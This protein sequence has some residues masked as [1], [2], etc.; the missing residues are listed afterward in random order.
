[1]SV[2][3]NSAGALLVRAGKNRT[4]ETLGRFFDDG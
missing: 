1:M 2:L 3:V 4:A